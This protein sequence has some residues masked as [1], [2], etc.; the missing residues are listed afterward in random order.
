MP[1]VGDQRICDHYDP[2][3]NE[4]IRRFE[5]C[6]C[7]PPRCICGKFVKNWEDMHPECYQRM[8][9]EE[10]ADLRHSVESEG[11]VNW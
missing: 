8:L 5:R 10:E 6:D 3:T 9:D 4:C 1:R 2:E 7:N 11:M